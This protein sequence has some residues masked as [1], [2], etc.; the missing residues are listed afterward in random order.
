MQEVPQSTA[1]FH[2]GVFEADLASG[3]LRKQGSRIR[4]QEQPFQILVLLLDHAGEVV[5][6]EELCRKLWARDTF[7]DFE[8]GLSTAIKKLRQALSDDAETPRYIETL[9]KR[10]YRF[11]AP[12]EKPVGIT[13]PP[14]AD[15]AEAPCDQLSGAIIDEVVVPAASRRWLLPAVVGGTIAAFFMAWYFSRASPRP[16][17]TPRPQR[18]T[19]NS[20]E[21]TLIESTLSPDGR[22][23]AY[24]DRSGIHLHMIATRETWT[25]PRPPNFSPDD[26]WWPIAFFPDGNRLLAGSAVATPQGLKLAA[27]IVL[28][29][30]G[31]P[32]RIRQ[33]CVAHSISP[34]GALIL[35]TEGGVGLGHEIWVMDPEGGAL[36]KIQSAKDATF[37]ALRWSR[38]GRRI[39]YRKEAVDHSRVVVESTTLDGSRTVVLSSNADRWGDFCWL[40]RG[41]LLFS[42]A[43]GSAPDED[44]NLWELPTDP[45]TGA[46]SGRPRKLTDWSGFGIENLSLSSDATRLAFDKVNSQTDVYIGQLGRKGF[47]VP[48]H[49]LTLDDY[50]DFP[51]AWSNDSRTVFFKIDRLGSGSIL[52]QNLDQDQAEPVVSGRNGI[53]VVRLTPDGSSLI[54]TDFDS[55]TSRLMLLPLSSG[56]PQLLGGQSDVVNVACSQKPAT[57]CI[58][59]TVDPERKRLTFVSIEPPN[60]E[61][62][63]LFDI[64]FEGQSWTVSPNGTE[65]AINKNHLDSTEID[66]FSLHGML[67]RIIP[68]KGF[69]RFLS[70]DWAP[71]GRSWFVGAATTTGCSLL[72]LYPDGSYSVL[73]NMHGRGMRTYAIPSPNGRYLAFLG[74]TVNRNAWMIDHF[75]GEH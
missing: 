57:N 2:F 51:Y 6:R 75:Q 29:H 55:K 36:R 52:K 58:A 71:D 69:N 21:N 43:A 47:A 50:D 14:S 64:E 16:I 33:D 35:F 41:R 37:S 39:A 67:E 40:P 13:P 18:V 32:I 22:V 45:T 54:Y 59:G 28:I 48:P 49:R 15:R 1:V 30:S 68:V 46:P 60:S 42:S 3:E 74:W 5:G 23:V 62:R 61:L 34:D 11:I 38:D 65:I 53:G 24:A 9:P 70:I 56:V 8:Q 63:R 25:V 66:I 7:V 10:G 12:V 44:M 17:L 4:L 72:R 19:A 73:V 26:S 27:W 20:T 31:R